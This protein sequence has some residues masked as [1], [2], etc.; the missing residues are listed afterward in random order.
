MQPGMPGADGR[1]LR[2]MPEIRGVLG[3]EREAPEGTG[4]GPEDPGYAGR[5]AEKPGKEGGTTAAMAGEV[6][7]FSRFPF[8]D[9]NTLTL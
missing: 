6:K 1:L 3:V 4:A 5:D 7:D 9:R 8:F 2:E